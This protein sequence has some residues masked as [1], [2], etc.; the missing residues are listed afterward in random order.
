MPPSCWSRWP[1]SPGGARGHGGIALGAGL[2][3]YTFDRYKARK[4]DEKA[5]K[6]VKL[7]FTLAD[8]A[9]AKKLWN[10]REAVLEGTNLS[11]DLVQEPANVLGPE[12]FAR[13]CS[14][15]EKLGVEV[16]VLDEKKLKKLGMGAPDVAS[17]RV[18]TGRRASSS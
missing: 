8:H 5:P 18:P 2:R 17:P 3:A 4:K 6:S 13:R 15:L 10:S 14:E 16:D 7:T 1:A 11:R 9:A 12:E